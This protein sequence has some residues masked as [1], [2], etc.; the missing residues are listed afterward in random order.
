M[1]FPLQSVNVGDIKKIQLFRWLPSQL[2]RISAVL[3][4]INPL[5]AE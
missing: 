5:N 4:Y 1:S 2:I 3:L